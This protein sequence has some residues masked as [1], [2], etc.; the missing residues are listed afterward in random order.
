MLF[1]LK[2]SYPSLFLSLIDYEQKKKG[3]ATDLEQFHD[4]IQQMEQHVD[5]LSQKKKDRAL[6]LEDTNRKLARAAGRVE[7]LKKC[8]GSQSLSLDDVQKMQNEL[9]GVEEAIGRAHALQAE[10]S[11]SLWEGRT[12]INALL[13][14]LESMAATYN[15]KRAELNLLPFVLAEE[16]E[17]G[18]AVDRKNLAESDQTRLLGVNMQEKVQT[19]MLGCKQ[20]YCEEVAELKLRYQESLDQAER[21]EE[22]F[23]EALER[24]KIVEGKTDKHEESLEAERQSQEAKLDVRSRE[25]DSMDAKV[26]SLRNPVAI[27]E[28]IA[29]YERQCAELEALLL[30]NEQENVTRKKAVFDEISEA[31]AAI[32]EYDEF[33]KSK[34]EE[35]NN[36]REGR[37]SSYGRILRPK[38]L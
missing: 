9:K 22:A 1:L 31:C 8:I 14:E 23:A 18:V 29:Q 37:E 32:K 26:A 16:S 28:Q 15:A 3:Y 2:L 25:A 35:V 21:S 11:K 38:I 17:A 12:E 24:L 27:E 20:K 30:K 4:L 7:D 34:I 19:W 6:E 5:T 33:C 10:H 36:Y 13:S